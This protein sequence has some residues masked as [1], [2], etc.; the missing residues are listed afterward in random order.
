MWLWRNASCLIVVGAVCSGCASVTQLSISRDQPISV[1][2]K[3]GAPNL[4]MGLSVDAPDNMPV[5]Q[6]D[7][8][9]TFSFGDRVVSY[10]LR[11]VME[12]AF[13]EG[14]KSNFRLPKPGE[15]PPYKILIAVLKSQL[16][17]TGGKGQYRVEV[18][19]SLCDRYGEKVLVR[20][21]DAS[22][23]SP[24]DKRT[25]P[26][27]VWQGAQSIC[28]QFLGLIGG[29]T[30]TLA[31]LKK[32]EPLTV[33]NVYECDLQVLDLAGH[34][35]I[36]VSGRVNSQTELRA[37]AEDLVKKLDQKW[38]RQATPKAAV[39]DFRTT[40]AEK[41]LQIGASFASFVEAAAEKQDLCRILDRKR[42]DLIMQ[43]HDLRTSDIAADPS[44][45]GTVQ[46]PL[47]TVQFFIT[48]QI[49]VVGSD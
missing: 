32:A 6:S 7:W 2:N 31:L 23:S 27:A 19:A 38:M 26:D 15:I 1:L 37:M 25:V 16:R 33:G 40:G 5:T 43:E 9:M 39:L 8:A 18:L 20:T 35:V 10:P 24:Y 28:E 17:S 48:G 49:S 14:I 12:Q 36:G 3:V 22:A 46:I 21:L 45:L 41:N 30:R 44:R 11:I 13:T 47:D 42:L 34:R 4:P 29:D